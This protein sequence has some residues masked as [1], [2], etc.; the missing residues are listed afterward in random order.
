MDF[1][2]MAVMVTAWRRPYYL[3]PVL[4]SWARAEGIG[5]VRRFVIS[6]G[7]TDRYEKQAALIERMRPRFPGGLEVLDQSEAAMRGDGIRVPFGPHRAIA[8]AANHVFADPGVKFLIFGE[9]DVQVS[10][11]TL[12]WM[13][14]AA[15]RFA[16]D[17]E[18][19][20]VLAHNQH[21]QGWDKPGPA[22][23]ANA[24]QEA[25]RLLPYFNPWC[26]GTWR[27][28]WEKILEPEWDYGCNSGGPMDS[29]YDWAIQTKILPRHRML[30]VV[31]D[32]SRS[33]NIGQFEGW[34]SSPQGVALAQAQSFRD[35]RD[36]PDYRLKVTVPS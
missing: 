2:D 28:R 23:D 34:A 4:A 26:F 20:A 8:E 18:V 12:S 1:S 19:L 10:D 36:T 7:R 6:L 25:A 27:D 11:D 33:Q 29:G 32:A 15:D 9:E 17:T 31:P 30:C 16:D 13:R 35:H 3:E 21:G 5:D 14:W 22:G 24:D